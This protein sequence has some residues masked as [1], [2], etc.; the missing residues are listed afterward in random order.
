MAE[1]YQEFPSFDTA[2]TTPV[3]EE[4]TVQQELKT[5]LNQPISERQ[6]AQQTV[7]TPVSEGQIP[8]EIL[9]IPS[10]GAELSPAKETWTPPAFEGVNFQQP[11]IP[12]IPEGDLADQPWM[13]APITHEEIS[14]QT[15]SMPGS[16]EETAQLAQ[17]IPTFWND[18]DFQAQLNQIQPWIEATQ[19]A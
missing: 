13:I 17:I 10:I 1:F 2:P 7:E 18:E 14:Q 8:Q 11:W 4:E 3:D 16:A 12:L 6:T 15:F 5:E 19:P 9:P